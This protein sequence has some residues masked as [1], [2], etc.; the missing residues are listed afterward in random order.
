MCIS[1]FFSPLYQHVVC[2]RGPGLFEYLLAENAIVY[3]VIV[4]DYPADRQ[5][6][7]KMESTTYY[8]GMR[9][10]VNLLVRQ[11]DMTH[12]TFVD[13]WLNEHAPIAESLPGVNRYATSVP[14]DPN[15]ATYDG[16]AEL[17]IESSTDISDVFASE[18]GQRIQADTE[19]FLD[20]DAGEILIVD[21]TV[22]FEADN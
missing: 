16:I 6:E 19:N 17:Y 1:E 2:E 22:Q 9:K 21:E 3:I 11:E 15:Q 5:N 20:T 4:L 14:A 18:T 7:T 10:I 12:E 13:Y 8:I